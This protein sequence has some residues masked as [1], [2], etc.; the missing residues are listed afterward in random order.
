MF[1]Q[2]KHLKLSLKRNLLIAIDYNLSLD[3]EPLVFEPHTLLAAFKNLR[4]KMLKNYI[5][6]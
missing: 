4:D 5:L 1:N 2:L 3:M 6:E